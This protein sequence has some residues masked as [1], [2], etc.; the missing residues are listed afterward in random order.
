MNRDR[1][2]GLR[3]GWARLDGAAGSQVVD[4]VIGAMSDFMG[5][6]AM[7]NHGGLFKAAGP[8][9]RKATAKTIFVAV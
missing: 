9:R 8:Q 1:F 7:A 2:P 5:S 4:S 3:D 6:G